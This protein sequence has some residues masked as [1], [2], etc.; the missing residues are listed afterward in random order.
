M[1]IREIA[2]MANVSIGTV[3]R[4][5][6]NRAGVSSA[7]KA[8][9]ESIVEQTGFHANAYA[10]NLKLGKKAVIGVMIPL[11]SSEYG[12]WNLVLDGIRK[13]EAEFSGF[14]L[15][16]KYGFYDRDKAGDFTQAFRT[17]QNEGCTAYLIAPLPVSEFPSAELRESGLPVAFIDSTIPSFTPVAVIAQNPFKGGAAAGR[18]MRLLCGDGGI[19]ITLQIHPDAYN[20]YERARGFSSYMRRDSASRT[21]NIDIRDVSEI[22]TALDSA[23]QSYDGIRGIFSVNCIICRVGDYLVQRHLKERVAAVGY[24]LVESNRSALVNGSVDAIISQ[25]PG[26]Q[27]YTALSRLFRSA[28]YDEPLSSMDEVPIDI[29]FR[30]NLTES[31]E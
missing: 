31:I 7:T 9:I 20:S 5:L 13:A 23:F 21:V 15:A 1:T 22:P 14:G 16:L 17:L 24:D 19:F 30:E 25:R 6:N 11:G 3:D 2:Q 28:A 4:V 27:G 8:K 12:Y 29:F 18:V 10:R 26:F